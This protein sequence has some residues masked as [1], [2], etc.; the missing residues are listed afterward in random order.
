MKRIFPF[1][2]L[3][4]LVIAC[5]SITPA[6]S[7]QKVVNEAVPSEPTLIEKSTSKSKQAVRKPN[8]QSQNVY[9]SA[10]F[11]FRFK[12]PNG[13]VVDNSHENRQPKPSETWQG[14]IEIWK[15]ADYRAIQAQNFEGTE[16]PPNISVKVHSNLNQRPLSYWKDTLSI[17]SR[18]ARAITVASQNA[19]AYS[20]TGLYEFEN[21]LLS[22][23]DGRRVIHLSRGYLN[24]SDSSRQ[25]F[26]QVVSSFRFDKW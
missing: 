12:Y 26:Q 20:S 25:A 14:T 24:A 6:V 15:N 5:S 1:G 21:V 7:T 19:L 2:L 17:G 11:G 13:Y 16:L 23:P 9:P 18:N 3:A 10:K 8:P 4:L 22:S